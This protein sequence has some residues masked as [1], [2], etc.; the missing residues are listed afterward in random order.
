MNPSNIQR[1]KSVRS[2]AGRDHGR[3]YVVLDWNERWVFVAN[4]SKRSIANPKK[5]N[6]QHLWYSKVVI[7]SLDEHTIIDILTKF[8]SEND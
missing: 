8:A 7:E 2:R 1:G 3:L 4:G 5:K 6:I